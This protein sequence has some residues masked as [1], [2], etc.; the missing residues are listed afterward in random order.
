MQSRDIV[1]VCLYE[2]NIGRKLEGGTDSTTPV[3]NDKKPGGAATAAGKNERDKQGS[4][5][6]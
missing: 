2:P 1:V 6:T 5:R 4:T 3:T